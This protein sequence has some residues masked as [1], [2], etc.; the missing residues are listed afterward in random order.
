MTTIVGLVQDDEVW[1]GGDSA[2]SD[3]YTTQVTIMKDPKVFVN[4]GVLLGFC[5]S[6]RMGNLLR[7]SF[8]PPTQD[9]RMDDEEYVHTVFIDAVRDTFREGGFAEIAR[10]VERAVESAFLI[11]Y[12]GHLYLVDEGFDVSTPA[13]PY[14]SV[15]C[16]AQIALGAMHVSQALDLEPKDRIV[17]ALKASER[18]S[19]GVRGPF[20]VQH[21]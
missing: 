15:G 13:D 9:I 6:A 17:R 5:G 12:R 18:F 8:L 10:N 20:V 3:E 21:I 11:G 19:N 1:M 7:W 4:N 14:T 16:G 2:F